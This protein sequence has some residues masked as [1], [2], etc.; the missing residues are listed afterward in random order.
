MP[1]TAPES[2]TRG[3]PVRTVRARARR[4]AGVAQLRVQLRVPRLEDAHERAQLEGTADG[5]HLGKL[6]A[7]AEN[8]EEVRRLACDTPK[9]PQLV[10][11]DAPGHHGEHEQDEEHDL[12]G[13]PRPEDQ[14]D[15]PVADNGIGTH[16]WRPFDST[17]RRRG[18]LGPLSVPAGRNR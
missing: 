14:V 15:D 3:L 18:N 1:H 6:G 11:D 13:G 8:V 10:Q 12:G 5:L 4:L 2:W 7:P 9:V 17:V 16:A